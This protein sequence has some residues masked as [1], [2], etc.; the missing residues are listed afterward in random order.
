MD[1]VYIV[2][3]LTCTV[4]GKSYIGQTKNKAIRAWQHSRSYSRC[5]ALRNA[6]RKHGWDSFTFATLEEGLTLDAANVREEQLI[7]EHGTLAP[8]GYNLVPGG[9]NHSHT[10]A[11]RRKLSERPKKLITEETRQKL[12]TARRARPPHSEETKQKIAAARIGSRHSEETLAKMRRPRGK[13]RTLVNPVIQ[14]TVDGTEV[15]RFD[16]PRDVRD[17]TGINPY[18]CLAGLSKSAG[19]FVWLYG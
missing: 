17:R 9:R 3:K 19:G 14:R 11:T 5:T 2:Y 4:T 8:R 15:A 6:V 18:N 12:I 10:E 16:S 1:H 13:Q 7:L